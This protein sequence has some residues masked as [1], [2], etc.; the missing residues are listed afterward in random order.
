MPAEFTS[1][2]RGLA[3]VEDTEMSRYDILV[4]VTTT[5]ECCTCRVPR[6]NLHELLLVS[7]TV[8]PHLFRLHPI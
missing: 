2:V 1:R 6:I 8:Q 5:L 7:T 3:P 4:A